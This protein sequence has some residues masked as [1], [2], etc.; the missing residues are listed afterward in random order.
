MM[1]MGYLASRDFSHAAS[2]WIAEGVNILGQGALLLGVLD[3]H[4][5]G[6]AS[7]ALHKRS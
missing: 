1:A 6:L 2:H 4:R 7:A 5:H 3:L